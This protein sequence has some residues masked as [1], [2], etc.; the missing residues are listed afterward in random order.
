MWAF[1]LFWSSRYDVSGV[2][3]KESYCPFNS[4]KKVDAVN[5]HTTLCIGHV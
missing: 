4:V 3:I 5:T 1:N 2:E